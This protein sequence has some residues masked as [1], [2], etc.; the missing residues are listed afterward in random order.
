[1]YI[2]TFLKNNHSHCKTEEIKP[3]FPLNIKERK[4]AE[5]NETLSYRFKYE[6]ENEF[7]CG[8]Y[9]LKTDGNTI[10]WESR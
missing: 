8:L 1:M 9:F 10:L 5:K 3:F 7:F 4:H 6:K 2:F